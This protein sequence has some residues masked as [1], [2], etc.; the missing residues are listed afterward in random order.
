MNE[1]EWNGFG[2]EVSLSGFEAHLS[3]FLLELKSFIS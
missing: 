1:M 3:R 2:L